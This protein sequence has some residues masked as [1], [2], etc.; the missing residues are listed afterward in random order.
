MFVVPESR[1]RVQPGQKF[2]S[3]TILGAPFWL[4]DASQH[5]QHVVCECD[6]GRAI[7]ARVFNVL[8]GQSNRCTDCYLKWRKRNARP[9]IPKVIRNGRSKTRLYRIHSAMIARCEVPARPN[10]YRYGGRGIRVCDEWR[11]SFEVFRRWSETNGYDDS[12]ELDRI[13]NDRDY[14]PD[15]CRWVTHKENMR[16]RPNTRFLTA[17]G[18]T[19]AIADWI[20]DPR[21]KVTA[22]G[23]RRRLSTGMT[24]EEAIKRP[25]AC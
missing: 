10:F 24:P 23:L 14:C 13:D 12:L 6:C 20:L 7:M 16:N 19:K 11:Q 18:E 4:P 8:N 25:P 15:N 21:C 3:L 9:K 17:W 5:H 22:G 2:H 1:R